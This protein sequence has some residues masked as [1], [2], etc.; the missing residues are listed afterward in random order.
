MININY[1]E[2]PEGSIEIQTGLWAL[3][4]RFTFAGEEIISHHLY[5]AEGYVF[6]E[7]AQPE[8]YDEE[9]NLLPLEQRV[10]ATYAST[11]YETIA[12]LNAA[13]VSVPYQEGYEVV[14]IGND[15]V[16]E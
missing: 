8:N 2:I 4:H 11:P 9:G 1:R 10:F 12:E 7:V 3:E 15:H 14:S 16:T 6:W 13:F 5:S